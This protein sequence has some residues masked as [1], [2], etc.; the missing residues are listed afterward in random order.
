MKAGEIMV[1]LTVDTT[2]LQAALAELRQA[3]AEGLRGVKIVPV[4]A[5]EPLSPIPD[6]VDVTEGDGER[7]ADEWDQAVVDGYIERAFRGLLRSVVVEG[8]Q[9]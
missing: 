7:A 5:D 4:G 6:T 2:E 1:K 9:S 3:L 8:G